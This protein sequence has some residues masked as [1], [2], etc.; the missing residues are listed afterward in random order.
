MPL[1]SCTHLRV[2]GED[3]EQAELFWGTS[4]ELR[5]GDWREKNHQSYGSWQFFSVLLGPG[6]CILSA[7]LSSLM[8]P[9][10]CFGD[11]PFSQFYSDKC[12][13]ELSVRADALCLLYLNEWLIIS[14]VVY[15]RLGNP[16]KVP[17]SLL[18]IHFFHIMFVFQIVSQSKNMTAWWFSSFIPILEL[19]KTL[20]CTVL[21]HFSWLCNNPGKNN[22][23]CRWHPQI[24]G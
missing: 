19:Y 8:L 18:S 7:P 17:N 2:T 9:S 14:D 20:H 22:F 6:H 11:F 13:P 15:L 12:L 5:E 1:V 23:C 16:A 10:Y 21:V 3:M 24:S 4:T